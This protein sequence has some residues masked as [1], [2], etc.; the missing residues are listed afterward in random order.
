MLTDLKHLWQ[1]AFTLLP[2]IALN[3]LPVA[4]M[5]QHTATED[6]STAD[7]A[8]FTI[9]CLDDNYV[10][11]NWTIKPGQADTRYAL[12]RSSDGVAF[13]TIEQ[14][15]GDIAGSENFQ[16]AYFDEHPQ[17]VSSFYRL[18]ITTGDKEVTYSMAKRVKQSEAT[19][20]SLTQPR[21]LQ[22]PV[23]ASAQTGK[24][25]PVLQQAP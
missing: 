24:P 18:R 8:G 13:E 1:R 17:S 20:G 10:I 2:L 21:P 4:G 7:P 11:A 22:E 25:A 5:A 19:Y 23:M 9:K 6:N 16:Y 12:E 14:V 3:C 15:D